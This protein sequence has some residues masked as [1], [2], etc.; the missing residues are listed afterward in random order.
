MFRH[1]KIQNLDDF[2]KNLSDRGTCQDI[3]FYRINGYTEE[4]EQFIRKYYETARRRGVVIEGKIPNPDEKNLSYYGEIMGMDFVLSLEFIS[5][6][7]EKWLPR[8]KVHQRKNVADS[9][10]NSLSSLRREGK[11]DNMLRNAYIKFMCWFYYKFE[12]IVNLLGEE[13]IPKILYEGEISRYE[14]MLIS[15]LANAGCDVVLLQY[16]GDKKYLEL[17]PKSALSDELQIQS[18]KRTEI[19]GQER[20][21]GPGAENAL[22][23]SEMKAFP[24]EFNLKWLREQ[25]QREM[26]AE[27]LYGKKPELLNCTNAWISGKGLDDI[28]TPVMNRRLEGKS[29][30]AV[31]ETLNGTSDPKLFYNCFLLINGVEDRLTYLNELYQFG[32]E[33][34]AAGRPVVIVNGRIQ[35]PSPEEIA[36]IRRQNYRNTDELLMNLSEN[37]HYASKPELQRLMVKAFVDIMKEEASHPDMNLNK[38]TGKAVYLLCWLKRYQVQLFQAWKMPE[39]SCFIYMAGNGL[40]GSGSTESRVSRSGNEA[41]GLFLKMLSRLPTDVLILNP[42]R[43]HKVEFGEVPEKLQE[44][45]RK[46][47]QDKMLYE[48]NFEESLS[49]K[50]FPEENNSV[51]MGTAAYHAERELDTL[52]YQNSGLYREKQYQKAVSV[53]LQTMYEEIWMLWKEDLKYRPNFST[54]EDKV[55]MPVIFAKVSGVKDGSVAH[56]WEKIQ[57]LITEDTV[58]VKN[59]PFLDPMKENPMKA[60]AV[61]FYRNHRLQREKIKKHPDYPYGFLREEIQEHILDKLQLLIDEKLIRGT[62][63]NGTEYTIIATVLN[64]PKEILRLIQKFDFTKKNPKMV[65]INTGEKIMSLEDSILTAFLNLVGFDIVFFIP[66]G[67]QNIEKH[68]NRKVMEEHQAGEYL[69]DLTVPDFRT[70]SAS[71]PAKP[72]SWIERLFGGGV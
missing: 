43:N 35:P 1:Q 28:R 30:G 69:Y 38:L 14:L 55:N 6:S 39:I 7:L 58:V 51:Q 8:M 50:E 31:N 32:Q 56:Y 17:D 27:R 15:I 65:Y 18:L 62:F 37:I 49:V 12:R 21:M 61:G 10:Y 34:K 36:G 41:E 47:L 48:L 68:F 70:V 53:S 24:A 22:S 33:L 4:I 71:S 13:E 57:E 2:F 40:A 72:K 52:M 11:N 19:T 59:V 26:N 9:I 42:D 23:G 60:P 44:N 5:T 3:Y 20:Y 63:E 64:L 66:T 45:F 46:N 54:T 25:I 16:H 67:Y 29:D